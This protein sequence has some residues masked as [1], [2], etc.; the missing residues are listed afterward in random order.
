MHDDDAPE[1]S[2]RKLRRTG[3]AQSA[4]FTRPISDVEVRGRAPKSFI[5]RATSHEVGGD[6]GGADVTSEAAEGD[7][8]SHENGEKGCGDG[9]KRT[10]IMVDVEHKQLNNSGFTTVCT[11]RVLLN[12]ARPPRRRTKEIQKEYACVQLVYRSID[13]LTA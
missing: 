4:H 8:M 6:A 5:S 10:L 2:A 11:S 3:L 7:G 1:C 9:F 12:N 13:N